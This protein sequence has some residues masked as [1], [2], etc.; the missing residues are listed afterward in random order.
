M[1]ITDVKLRYLH[2]EEKLKAV[3]SITIDNA[4]A[5]HDIKLIETEGRLFLAMPSRRLSDGTFRDVVHPVNAEVRAM[6]EDKL[7]KMYREDPNGLV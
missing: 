5:V 1:E 2:G 3:A 6:L 7:L 4:L